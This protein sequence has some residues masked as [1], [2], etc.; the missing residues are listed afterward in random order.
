MQAYTLADR[1][2]YLSMKSKI[3]LEVLVEGD[4]KL[5]NP[6]G[7]IAVNPAKHPHVNY[8]GAMLFIA[9]ITS[10]EGQNI[11][12]AVQREGQVLFYPDALK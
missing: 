5:F 12:S 3:A 4:P 10:P 8:N 2:T 7:I 9:W 11:I 6:Y 1:G